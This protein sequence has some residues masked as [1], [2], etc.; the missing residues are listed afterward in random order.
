[1]PTPRLYIQVAKRDNFFF[2]TL[3][4]IDRRATGNREIGSVII[5]IQ[6]YCTKVNLYMVLCTREKIPPLPSSLRHKMTKC[7]LHNCL[8][9][10]QPKKYKKYGCPSAYIEV[11]VT[12]I[13]LIRNAAD[14]STTSASTKNQCK[15]IN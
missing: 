7:L 8:F 2:C 11:M 15:K 13:K 10:F 3:N 1:M 6:N 12:A 14:R 5:T 4:V 9:I